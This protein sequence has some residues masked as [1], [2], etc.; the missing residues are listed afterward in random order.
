[1]MA[2]VVP[3]HARLTRTELERGSGTGR[4]FPGGRLITCLI[5]H[6]PQRLPRG[7]LAQTAVSQPAINW[8]RTPEGLA[9]VTG[10]ATAALTVPSS[11]NELLVRASKGSASN[12][13]YWQWGRNH[14]TD[15]DRKQLLCPMCG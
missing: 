14:S 11:H 6:A 12:Q 10:P 8:A 4:T 7:A 2:C 15:K 1:M 13:M 3:D 9:H 5:P